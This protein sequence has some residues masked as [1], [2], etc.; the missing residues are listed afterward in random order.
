MEIDLDETPLRGIV[1]WRQM[2]AGQTTHRHSFHHN[3]SAPRFVYTPEG[4]RERRIER[5]PRYSEQQ[6]EKVH[7]AAE[8][9]CDLIEDATGLEVVKVGYAPGSPFVDVWTAKEGSDDLEL[10]QIDEPVLHAAA[11]KFAVFVATH[12]A[13]EPD[14]PVDVVSKRVTEKAP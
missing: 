7:T 14:Q 13:S 11:H 4:T 12:I 5:F 8:T 9:L 3:E 1:Q 6:R 10:Y 2:K